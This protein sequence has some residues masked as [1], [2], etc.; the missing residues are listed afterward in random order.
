MLRQ[1][2]AMVTAYEGGGL[3]RRQLVASLAGLATAAVAMPRV[4]G[5]ED[6]PSPTFKATDLN[7]IALSVTDVGRSRDFY[8]RHLGLAVMTQGRTNCFMRCSE[9][10]FVA[11]F[12]SD[13]PAMHH[14]CYSVAGYD[15]AQAVEKLAAVDIEARRSGNRV[16]FDDP[17]G[18]EVQVAAKG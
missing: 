17:D 16:Y 4:A 2:E 18:L 9:T 3:S 14:Y 7:H 13:R 10:N 6:E 11:L 1:I 15:P 5:A 12:K 8:E